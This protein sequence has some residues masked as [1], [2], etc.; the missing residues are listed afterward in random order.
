MQKST[1]AK[2]S[3]IAIRKFTVSEDKRKKIN[4][5]QANF[6]ICQFQFCFNV[7]KG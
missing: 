6:I 4:S 2:N 7:R 3:D 1:N 5:N